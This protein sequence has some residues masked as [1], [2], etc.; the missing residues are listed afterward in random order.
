M[1]NLG[2]GKLICDNCFRSGSK[3]VPTNF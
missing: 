2:A 3:Q 1:Q